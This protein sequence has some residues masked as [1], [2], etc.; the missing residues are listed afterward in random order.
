[1]PRLEPD[2]TAARLAPLVGGVLLAAFA[3]PPAKADARPAL[4]RE[5]LRAPALGLDLLAWPVKRGLI[6]AEEVNLPERLRSVLYFNEERTA[7]WFPN[8]SLGGELGAGLGLRSFH[9]D[10]WGHGERIEASFLVTGVDVREQRADLELAIPSVA[11]SSFGLRTR[12]FYQE[13]DDE[14]LFVDERP[15]SYELDVVRVGLELAYAPREHLDLGV[16]LTPAWASAEPGSGVEPRTL[17]GIDGFGTPVVTLTPALFV[18]WDS[19]DSSFRPK[20]GLAARLEGG[21]GAGLTGETSSGREYA[22]SRHTV[23]VTYFQPVIARDRALVLHARLDKV[24]PT[25]GGAVPFW[26]L[27]KLDEDHGLR[28][29]GRNRF[30]D[31]GALLFNVEYRYPVWDTWDAYV[32]LDEGQV[33]EE[34]RDLSIARFEW[35]AGGGLLLSTRDAFALRVEC[36]VGDEG[37]GFT[38]GV[39]QTFAAFD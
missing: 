4:G 38:V 29:F 28:A 37:T 23:E 36:A 1:M 33:F 14:D 8:F 16:V 6:L 27:P 35:S 30:R 26:E 32:F 10:L 12:F 13:D 18:A 25:G 9:E 20:S 19:R 5:L 34:Y 22:W 15:V 7:G 39:D 21:Y 11:G 24:E 17:D 31:R 2:R 3:T